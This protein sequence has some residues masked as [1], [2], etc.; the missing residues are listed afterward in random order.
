MSLNKRVL[1]MKKSLLCYLAPYMLG[2]GILSTAFSQSIPI[3]VPGL[4]KA[5]EQNAQADERRNAFQQY[6]ENNPDYLL[7]KAAPP[8]NRDSE[9]DQPEL[10]EKHE[11][12]I[13][14]DPETKRVP[15]EQL[16]SARKSIQTTLS[17]KQFNLSATT[18]AE[19][20]PNNIGGRTR[21]IL[22][23]PN[24]GTKKKVWAGG[25]AG[26]L[27]FNNDITDA[28]SSWHSVNDFWE[29]LAI[30]SL[31]YDPSNTQIMYA[32][33]GEGYG[34]SDAVVGGGIWKTVNGGT[35]WT[36]LNS[37]IPTVYGSPS[38]IGGAF[39][40]I[41]DIVVNASGTVFV[42][43]QY[44]MVKSAD[45]GVNW[46]FA[47]QPGSDYFNFV[48]DLEIG[49]DGVLYAAYGH[50]FA[51]NGSSKLFKSVN[52]GV[53]WTN[54]TPPGANG[55]R[56]EIALAPSTSGASQV[57]YAAV[58]YPPSA[59]TPSSR[60]I[61]LFSKSMDAGAT[62]TNMTI[63]TYSN[64]D[65]F[66][67]GQGWYDLI[68]AVHPTNPNFLYVG[69]TN[70]TRS[71]NGGTTWNDVLT[72][73]YNHPDQHAIVFRP[74]TPDGVVLGNDGGIY[75]SSNA[76]N[77]ATTT[78]ALNYGSR[79]KNYNITQYYSIAQK[80]VANNNYLLAGAQDNGTHNLSATPPTIGAG[81]S[82][83]GGDGMLC[84]ID[85]DNPNVQISSYQ[86]NSHNLLNGNGTFITEI[87]PY[88][89]GGR[90]VNPVDYDSQNNI[91]YSFQNNTLFS[92]V[93]NVGTT[94]NRDNMGLALPGTS[95]IKVAK[96]PNTIFVGTS[97]GGVYRVTNTDQPN[98][99][100]TQ[101][102]SGSPMVGNVSSIMVGS[103]DSQL[104]VT[105][106]NYNVSSVWYTP[107]GGTT[108]VNKDNA[109]LPNMPIRFGLFNELDMN[110]VMLATEMGV[111][112]TN[113]FLAASPTWAAINN[114][115]AHV[116]C[117]WLHYRAAD[118]QVAV[119]THGR[120]MFS[121]D[122]FST[123]N[124]PVS[125]T[126]TSTIPA[127]ICKG[128]SFPV[129]IFATGSF[130]S[131]NQFQIELSNSSGSFASGTTIIGTS[132]ITSVT[133]TIPDI[134]AIATGSNYYIR[135]KSTNPTAVSAAAGP[136]TISAGGLLYAASTPTVSSVSPNGFT[137]T[138]SLNASGK[139]Y[140]VVLGDN[141]P[142]PTNDQIMNGKASD[143][144]TALKWGM[145]DIPAAN[146]SAS[147]S[148]SGL[149]SGVNYDVYFYK[150]GNG[151][152]TS[153]A[154]ESP[155]KRDVLTSGSPLA[156][157]TPAY[158]NGCSI[159][160]VIADFQL[161]NTNLTYYNTGCSS[162]SFGYFGNT[163]TPLAQGQSY[164]FVFKTYIDETG[165]YYPQH[166]AIWIDLNRNGTF[167]TSERLYQSS[168]NSISNTW[169]GTLAIPGSASTGMT[170]MRI[171]TQYAPHGT[172][173]DPC[174]TYSYGETEDH[175]ITIEDNSVIVS[176]QTGD[177]DVGSTWI[178]GQVPS[179]TQKVV[180]QPGHM[181]RINGL[182]VSAKQ[183]SLV[184]GTLDVINNG[185]LLIDG[186]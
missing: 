76:G 133:A 186:Q 109:T 72:Y 42:A 163:S 122:A 139:V 96:S 108:W 51:G 85:Q 180:I 119:G 99:T 125:L 29:N 47:H 55:M 81:F 128:L 53:T 147:L 114:S 152:L 93:R 105:I 164:P 21:A 87:V 120:G 104:L 26:G 157:C 67:G 75:Y 54:I 135:A 70:I 38:T 71:F 60:D 89:T 106:S 58:R 52:N 171:R 69:G 95:F 110:Q 140:F 153:C 57:V 151:T 184:N 98:A 64:G 65:H 86:Y 129:E 111:W 11:V 74:G 130:V 16:E 10:R 2:W 182:N 14:M 82:S 134:P 73:W 62:W 124:A 50:S 31:A 91:L 168:G 159:G 177:W 169:S 185:L 136:F 97:S 179:G 23:D 59:P 166:I 141:T 101:I 142:V 66:T 84:F 156:Y 144:K 4:P 121:T 118:G 34:N 175:L 155:V 68:L 146:A 83:T 94:N 117:D 43:T 19:R 102:N 176:A 113:N 158:S 145:L 22:F 80:N 49:T 24:D 150:A 149:M 61:Q 173:N 48:S 32:G 5:N 27:W 178:G 167:E 20:G 40:N 103:N 9:G 35:T 174:T 123:A 126:I 137:V 100:P 181:V 7:L 33:T 6:L 15:Y 132:S 112:A 41:Q 18:W 12:L 165:T 116:R 162:N 138:A 36:R 172:V 131:G 78:N 1:T 63:P 127:S 77:V 90:F 143:N 107:D 28:N 154:G 56:M 160:V 170:R 46:S 183:V 37:T 88:G 148:V 25:V 30:S 92:R 17:Q 161:T 13:T 79:N 8:A 115:L 3:S 39:Q 44:G 45:G